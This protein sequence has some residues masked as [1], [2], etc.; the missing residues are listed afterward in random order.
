[1]NRD[2]YLFQRRTAVE[3]ALEIPHLAHNFGLAAG[4]VTHDTSALV[5]Y[6]HDYIVLRIKATYDSNRC[7]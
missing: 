4:E 6:M 1:M 7:L 5:D 2:V 3:V